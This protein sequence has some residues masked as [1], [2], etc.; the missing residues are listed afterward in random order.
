MKKVYILILLVLSYGTGVAAQV[1][2]ASQGRESLRVGVTH[3]PPL[4]IKY[5]DG[6]DGIAVRLWLQVANDLEVQYEF[7]EL[8]ED[9]YLAAVRAGVVDVVITGVATAE[10]EEELDFSHSYFSSSLGFAESG[11]RQMIESVRAFFSPRFWRAVGW[12]ALILLVVGFLTWILER[13]KNPEMFGG[14]AVQGIWSGF[15]WAAVT[16]TLIGYGDKTPRTVPGRILALFWMIIGLGIFAT[17]TATITSVLALR[18][19]T[20]FVFP[21]DLRGA[22][23]GAVADSSGGNYLR[24]QDITF[25]PLASPEEGLRAVAAGNL[26]FFVHETAILRH[27]NAEMSRGR[28]LVVGTEVQTYRYAFVLPPGD[29]LREPVNLAVLRHINSVSWSDLLRRFG[30]IEAP[31]R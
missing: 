15:W 27:F 18:A 1:A 31:G 26:D 28:L 16:V 23:V 8:S 14:G 20:G 6:W 4:A 9:E 19:A 11:D 21:E 24:S 22:R 17:L 7:V 2:P 12:L 13:R 30:A 25:E 10:A 3:R 5:E 29:P